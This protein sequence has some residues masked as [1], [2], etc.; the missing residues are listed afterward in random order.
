MLHGHLIWTLTWTSYF[1]Y[2]LR[3]LLFV[4]VAGKPVSKYI[5]IY[6]FGDKPVFY[7]YVYIHSYKVNP[8]LRCNIYIQLYFYEMLGIRSFF[9]HVHAQA[10]G[11]LTIMYVAIGKS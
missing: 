9:R 1:K 4:C 6:T 7:K 8:Y 10:Q 11:K 3:Q 5:Y 2:K